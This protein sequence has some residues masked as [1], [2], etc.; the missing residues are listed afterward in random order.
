[1]SSVLQSACNLVG[2]GVG[3]MLERSG[4]VD[5]AGQVPL[6]PAV[7]GSLLAQVQRRPACL[8]TAVEAAG[9]SCV[10]PACYSELLLALSRLLRRLLNPW[11]S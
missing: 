7:G 1:M 10:W 6:M 3:G 8:L 11:K 5:V 2:V 9:G 4:D